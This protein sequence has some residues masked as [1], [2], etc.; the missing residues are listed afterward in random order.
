MTGAAK[1]TVVKLLA[2]VGNACIEYQDKVLHDLP[3]KNIQC[4]EIWSFCYA[5]E[6]NVPVDHKGEFG[7]G[8][9]YTWTAICAD[10]KLVP[11]FLVGRRDA[12]HANAFMLDLASRL[13][14]RVQVIH[15]RTQSLFK[16]CRGCFRRRY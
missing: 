13:K 10:T 9:V 8:D 6:K 1:N 14:N 16:C 4:D 11:S 15:G 12:E 2:E 3:C 7:Y 5:K